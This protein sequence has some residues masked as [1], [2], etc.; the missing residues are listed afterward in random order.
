MATYFCPVTHELVK[1][2]PDGKASPAGPGERPTIGATF[3]HPHHGR[4]M[5]V[6]ANGYPEPLDDAAAAVPQYPTPQQQQQPQPQY[7]QQPP[8]APVAP[9]HQR[10]GD[11]AA[12][13][14]R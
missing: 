2:G 14:G 9:P 1:I 12:L 8:V 4:P 3:L 10:K 11:L 5:R 6:G 7:G 13:V